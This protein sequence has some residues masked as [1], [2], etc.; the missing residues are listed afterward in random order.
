METNI[1]QGIDKKKSDIEVDKDIKVND[2]IEASKDILVKRVKFT[3]N[4]KIKSFIHKKELF[5]NKLKK[6][7]NGKECSALQTIF[8]LNNKETF[9][10][11][12]PIFVDEKGLNANERI[13]NILEKSPID[14]SFSTAIGKAYFMNGFTRTKDDYIR[15]YYKRKDQNID[16]VLVDLY[17]LL[18]YDLE[19]NQKFITDKFNQVKSFGACMSQI[20]NKFI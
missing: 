16:I 4:P 11:D 14:I 19:K 10:E 6:I 1:F 18:A 9:W 5:S 12:V 13:L 8:S 20:L 17:H 2:D 15:I 3:I 7:D